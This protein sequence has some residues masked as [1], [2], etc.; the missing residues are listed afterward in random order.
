M[1]LQIALIKELEENCP[2]LVGRAKEI[3]VWANSDESGI[4]LK[5]PT[6]YNPD[7]YKKE[8]DDEAIIESIET[9]RTVNRKAVLSGDLISDE[10]LNPVCTDDSCLSKRT[11]NKNKK[12]KGDV[13]VGKNERVVNVYE[14]CFTKDQADRVVAELIKR[15]PGCKYRIHAER[16]C[17]NPYDYNHTVR[18]DGV[19]WHNTYK[20]LPILY[21]VLPEDKWY[22]SRDICRAS[23]VLYV[24]GHVPGFSPKCTKKDSTANAILGVPFDDSKA[25]QFKR[26]TNYKS[27]DWRNA[28]SGISMDTYYK[29]LSGKSKFPIVEPV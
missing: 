27:K 22:D 20:G 6:V 1:T 26:T 17:N 8:D 7:S 15:H 25:E 19:M 24:Y 2:D 16:T 21:F 5:F 9:E 10:D 23:Y 28:I 11:Y 4:S 29:D 18:F 3:K 14:P 12:Y 13:K